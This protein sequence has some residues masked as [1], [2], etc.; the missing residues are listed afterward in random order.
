M[1]LSCIPFPYTTHFVFA[2]ILYDYKI[3]VSHHTQK[4]NKYISILSFI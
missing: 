1:H 4:V 2:I 3:R